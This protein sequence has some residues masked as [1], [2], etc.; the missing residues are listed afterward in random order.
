[1]VEGPASIES[2][3]APSLPSLPSLARESVLPLHARLA[4]E[5][6]APTSG[7]AAHLTVVS[8]LN[9]L[10]GTASAYRYGGSPVSLGEELRALRALGSTQQQLATAAAAAPLQLQLQAA[11][12][13][14]GKLNAVLSAAEGRAPAVVAA[15]RAEPEPTPSLDSSLSDL[16]DQLDALLPPTT[17]Q[18]AAAMTAAAAPVNPVDITRR[19]ERGLEKARQG[20]DDFKKQFAAALV[21]GTPGLSP[22]APARPAATPAA[23]AAPT[24]GLSPL[25]PLAEVEEYLRGVREKYGLMLQSQGATPVK[26]PAEGPEAVVPRPSLATQTSRPVVM[27]RGVSAAHSVAPSSGPASGSSSGVPSSGSSSGA[28]SDAQSSDYTVRRH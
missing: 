5:L 9:Q 26:A 20:L 23:P 22:V 12:A 13:G 14:I 16:G 18:A 27:S 11:P 24:P 15:R 8:E 28:S 1:M 7:A 4:A 19:L 2:S 17:A 6:V 25:Q 21:P 10:L 3:P